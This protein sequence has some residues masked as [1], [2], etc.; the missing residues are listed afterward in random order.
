MALGELR[1]DAV[2]QLLHRSR[3]FQKRGSL[4]ARMQRIAL[5]Q[6]D[7]VVDQRLGRLGLG[8]RSNNVVVQNYAGD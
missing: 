7:H 1:S 4:A 2:E 5:G 3:S 6:R 8:H